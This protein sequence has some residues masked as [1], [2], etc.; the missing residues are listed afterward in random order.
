MQKGKSFNEVIVYIKS[1]VYRYYGKSDF[2]TLLKSYL[3][4]RTLRWQI[5]FRL[6]KGRGVET[7]R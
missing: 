4:N 1:D 3:H 2:M 7:F 5:A 6:S